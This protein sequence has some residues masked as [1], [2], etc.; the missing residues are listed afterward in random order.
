M[1]S[2]YR[3]EGLK[4]N[5]TTFLLLCLLPSQIFLRRF[6]IIAIETIFTTLDCIGDYY[7]SIDAS[8]LVLPYVGILAIM[9]RD[10]R[11]HTFSS[12][13]CLW[14]LRKGSIPSVGAVLADDAAART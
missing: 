1:C 13:D 3:V 2:C 5:A 11:D 14:S 10:V 12:L 6:F 7:Y 9:V 4:R 8:Y